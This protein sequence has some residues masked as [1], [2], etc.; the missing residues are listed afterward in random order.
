MPDGRCGR[1]L[2]WRVKRALN[3]I[4][5]RCFLSGPV[6]HPDSQQIVLICGL[7]DDG[8]GLVVSQLIGKSSRLSRPSAPMLRRVLQERSHLRSPLNATRKPNARID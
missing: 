1:Y 6:L 2:T 4:E 8:S 3:V 7:E 5:L